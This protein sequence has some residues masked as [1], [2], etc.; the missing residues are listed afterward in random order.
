MK[1][2]VILPLCLLLLCGGCGKKSSTAANIQEQYSRVATAQM[3]AEVTFH[4]PQ[5]DRSFTLQCTFTPEESTVTVTAPETVKGVTATVSGEE[6]T[7]AYDGAV[8]SAGILLLTTYNRVYRWT[9][10]QKA[11]DRELSAIR[12]ENTLLTYGVLACLKGLEEQGCDGP[13]HEAID[14]IER[15]LNLRAHDQEG[16][17]G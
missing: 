14:K 9:L 6:L 12:K 2:I 4:T 13:V 7:I 8:L 5:E 17:C 3:E 1:R 16:N 10:R 15:D 11:Q